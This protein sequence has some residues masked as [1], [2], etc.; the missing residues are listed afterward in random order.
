MNNVVFWGMG[1]NGV[2][3]TVILICL[4]IVY[5]CFHTAVGGLNT[6]T[7]WSAEPVIIICPF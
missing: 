4:H 7:I 1:R 5:G 3:Y 6:E 2:V